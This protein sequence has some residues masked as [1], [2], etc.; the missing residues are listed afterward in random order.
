M[1]KFQKVFLFVLVLFL[2]ACS[3]D[4]APKPRGFF[5]IDLPKKSYENYSSGCN[6][7][8]KIP[9]YA[10]V[11]NDSSQHTN[12]CWKNVVFPTINGRV[13]LSYYP[14][15]SPKLLIELMEN[16]RKLAFKHT[17]KADGIDESRINNPKHH[18]YGLYY[19]I[20]G[21]TASSIQFFV[22]DSSKHFLRG[23]LYFYT[24]PQ[25]DSLAPLIQFVKKDI[26]VMLESLEWK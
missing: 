11:W 23:A 16:A 4:Y 22:T 14:V 15:T 20:S 6:Y 17:V 10:A 21:N 9:T 7:S 3:S 2:A 19:E 5:R 18:V 24:E 26:D 13:H 12:E 25:A 1:F 8:F